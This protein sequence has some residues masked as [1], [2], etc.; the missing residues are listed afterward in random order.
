MAAVRSGI[1]DKPYGG[2]FNKTFEHSKETTV[3]F[4]A[5][6]FRPLSVPL[7]VFDTRMKMLRV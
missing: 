5:F 2:V 6:L 3:R 1:R 7:L 4:T